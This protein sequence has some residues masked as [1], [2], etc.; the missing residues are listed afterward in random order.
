MKSFSSY[1]LTKNI[2]KPFPVMSGPMNKSIGLQRTYPNYR[3]R[4]EREFV[5]SLGFVMPDDIFYFLLTHVSV[6]LVP[7]ITARPAG[8]F[9]VYRSPEE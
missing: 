8:L 6:F 3:S 7:A 1:W 2:E 5:P 9:S 4:M